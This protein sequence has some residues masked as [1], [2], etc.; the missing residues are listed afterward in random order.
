V[1]LIITKATDTSGNTGFACSTV[2]VPHDQS[3]ESLDAVNA[4]AFAAESFC[5]ENGGTPP[6]GFTQH[7]L[8]KEI[9]PKQ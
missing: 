9:G 4:Q 3:E 1:Y 7:G 6:A 5:N 2:V 8:S